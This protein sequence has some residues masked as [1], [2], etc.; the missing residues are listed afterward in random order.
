MFWPDVTELKSFYDSYLGRVTKLHL[1]K[2][3]KQIWPEVKGESI[4]AIGY[5]IPLL[6]PLAQSADVICAAMPAGLGVVHWP[7]DTPNITLLSHENA[8]PFRSET[9]NRI[10]ILHA[11]EHAQPVKQLLAETYRLLTPSGRM[12]LIVPN[13]RSFWARAEDTPY[14]QGQPYSLPQLLKLVDKAG[15]HSTY[16]GEALFFP[17]FKQRNLLKLFQW[18]EPIGQKFFPHFGGALI[19]EVE[20]RKNAPAKGTTIRSFSLT[21]QGTKAAMNREKL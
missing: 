7:I 17:P 16:R 20:K 11:L 1:R 6:R 9:L 3:V 21:A 14:A 13:R 2:A 15:F 4:L 18:L 5:P 10:I 19:I 8:F 12:L